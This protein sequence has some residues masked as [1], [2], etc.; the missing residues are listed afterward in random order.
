MWSNSHIK[1]KKVDTLIPILFEGREEKLKLK[2]Q[3]SFTYKKITCNEKRPTLSAAFSNLLQPLSLSSP[4][5]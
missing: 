5:A 2:K 1:D 3:K 4:S